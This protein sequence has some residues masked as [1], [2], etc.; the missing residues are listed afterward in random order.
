M[1]C[2]DVSATSIT[3]KTNVM[4]WSQPNRSTWQSQPTRMAWHVNIQPEQ[5]DTYNQSEWYGGITINDLTHG[6]LG[7]KQN[8]LIDA[9][10]AGFNKDLRLTFLMLVANNVTLLTRCPNPDVLWCAVWRPSCGRESGDPPKP[11][12]S[13]PESHSSRATVYETDL[14]RFSTGDKKC[15][16]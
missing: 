2:S 16:R 13:G 8:I 1:T 5:G 10:V 6:F 15:T 9:I 4:T 12:V 14:L 3:T 11:A 7:M